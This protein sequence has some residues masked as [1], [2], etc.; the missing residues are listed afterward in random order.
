MTYNNTLTWSSDTE[1]SFTCI[2]EYGIP[3]GGSFMIQVCPQCG[4][5][6]KIQATGF[7]NATNDTIVISVNEGL[8]KEQPHSFKI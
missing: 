6:D 5:S 2:T 1:F 8:K 3:P 4:V 7:V